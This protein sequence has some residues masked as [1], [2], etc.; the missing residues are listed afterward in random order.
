MPQPR[1]QAVPRKS[2]E[3]VKAA[4]AHKAFIDRQRTV[5]KS[6]FPHVEGLPKVYDAQ[7]AFNAAAGFISYEIEKRTNAFK[8]SE[9]EIDL[10]K[11]PEGPMKV[12]V[13]NILDTVKGENAMEAS[14]TLETMGSKLPGFIA[15][16]GLLLPMDTVKMDD[17][18]A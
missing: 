12:A 3:D 11:E 16:R 7:T 13:Q 14:K 5:A 4:L 8:V 1:K 10:S 15:N 9:L 17:F 18:I 2:K 6:V